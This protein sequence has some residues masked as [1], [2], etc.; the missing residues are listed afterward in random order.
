MPGVSSAEVLLPCSRDNFDASLA[1]FGEMGFRVLAI[2]PADAPTSALLCAYGVSLRL[3]VCDHSLP[4]PVTLRLCA[5]DPSTVAS[6]K[7]SL[8]SPNG[9]A[10]VFVPATLPVY[11]PPPLA[12]PTEAL[13]SA[14]SDAAGGFRAGRAGLLYRDLL[15]DRLGGRVIASHIR[16]ESEGP[17]PDYVHFH[18]VAFQAGAGVVGLGV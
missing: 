2:S 13:I 7:T 9:V 11:L 10:V 1:F 16:V 5:A 15:P 3:E 14:K 4:C 17:I 8:L 6:G 12:V 18:R